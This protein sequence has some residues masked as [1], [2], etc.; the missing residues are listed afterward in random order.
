MNIKPYGET[1]FVLP[2]EAPDR[3]DSGLILTDYTKKRPTSGTILA[4]GD[5]II[6]KKDELNKALKIIKECIFD[7]V[8][9]VLPL[10]QSEADEAKN[11][12]IEI[13]KIHLKQYS[14]NIGMRIVYGEFSGHRQIIN[15]DGEDKEIFIMTP[16]DI[17]ALLG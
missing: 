15:W 9:N 3:T 7:D 10:L 17:L 8:T 12:I 16:D 5:L 14:L 1:I 11:V 4:I 13:L 6:N 2:D